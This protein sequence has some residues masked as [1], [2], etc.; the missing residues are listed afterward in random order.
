MV[1]TFGPVNSNPRELLGQL[2]AE[3]QGIDCRIRQ[4]VSQLGE[5][6]LLWLSHK[7]HL[8]RML[9]RHSIPAAFLPVVVYIFYAGDVYT[10]PLCEYNGK[11]E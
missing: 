3:A 2:R 6:P 1:D 9:V 10:M 4:G 5:S 7:R 8:V 11:L